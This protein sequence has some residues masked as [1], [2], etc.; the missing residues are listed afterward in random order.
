MAASRSSSTAP[1]NM[2]SIWLH[3]WTPTACSDAGHAL[4]PC[5]GSSKPQNMCV[6]LRQRPV[7]L[8][9]QLH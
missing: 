7:N 8:T 5:D 3:I 1:Y 4:Q 6:L 9:P 2:D